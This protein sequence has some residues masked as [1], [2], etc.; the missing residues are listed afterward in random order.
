MVRKFF[1]RII[2]VVTDVMWRR[3]VLQMRAIDKLLSALGPPARRHT[4]A[5]RARVPGRR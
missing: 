3:D 5:S 2:K 4:R 1:R